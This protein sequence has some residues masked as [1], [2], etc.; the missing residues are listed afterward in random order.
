MVKILFASNN[1]AHWPTAIGGTDVMKFDSSRVPYSIDVVNYEVLRSPRFLPTTNE[2]T[3][4]HFRV[5]PIS[6][7]AGT[8]KFVEIFDS[9]DHLLVDLKRASVNSAFHFDLTTY[10]GATTN[11]KRSLAPLTQNKVN[12]VDIQY[13][14]TNLKTEVNVYINNFLSASIVT[15]ASVGGN[16]QPTVAAIGHAF[17]G[18]FST[19][20][21]VSEIFVADGD[22][23]NSRMN[24]LRPQAVG[25]YEQ[26]QGSILD[27][28]DED[29]T[30]GMSSIV[31]GQRQTMILS[32]YTGSSL[33]SNFVSVSQTTRGL[34]SPS[35]LKHTVRMSG[36]DYDSA[37]LPINYALQYNITDYTI[38][39]ATSQPF[40]AADIAA[41]E[42]GFLSVA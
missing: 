22:T 41:I 20:M 2:E 4:L 1:L 3:W 16:G 11:T 23:R 42:T 21:P 30:T 37:E 6:V 13:I 38:N 33:V 17:A 28:R 14:S 9:Q 26:W 40:T 29:T 24:L 8:R 10:D 32:A 25:A 31:A 39:P 35:K 18:S 7:D 36:V 12:S 27:L 34:N 15:G 19:P 5:Y